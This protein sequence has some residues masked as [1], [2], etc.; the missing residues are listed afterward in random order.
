MD[1]NNVKEVEGLQR[2]VAKLVGYAA[3]AKK[4]PLKNRWA[5]DKLV[6][7]GNAL[8]SVLQRHKECGTRPWQV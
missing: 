5:V 1:L 2:M 3:R 6:D 8:L 4:H 7:E